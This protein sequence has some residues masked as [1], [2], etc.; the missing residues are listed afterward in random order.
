MKNLKYRYLLLI[1]LVSSCG[2]KE[3]ILFKRI[4]PA[5]SHIEFSNNLQFDP[6]FNIFKY[7]NYY[8][9]GGVGLID[10]NQ[11][12]LLDIYLVANMETNRLYQ[13]LG[14]FQFK[15]VTETAG[16]GGVHAWSTG[17]TVADVN[18]DGWPDIYI[19]NSGDVEGDNRQNE[20]FINDGSGSFYEKA[21]EYGLADHGYSIHSAIFVLTVDVS[22]KAGCS[23]DKNIFQTIIINIS[24]A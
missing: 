22:A 5:Q 16:V 12:G 11:D 3:K 13:N 14:N 8:N 4:N 7:R 18:G 1:L 23:S 15:D 20:L 2:E 24:L 9:G 19:C 21:E 17:V 6:D 10:F